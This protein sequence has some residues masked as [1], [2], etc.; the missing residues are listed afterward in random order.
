MIDDYE[1]ALALVEKMKARGDPFR[2]SNESVGFVSMFVFESA[3][4]F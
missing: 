2:T 4:Y 1:K 3:I